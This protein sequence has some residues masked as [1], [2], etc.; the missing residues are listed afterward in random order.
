[1]ATVPV[2]RQ[3]SSTSKSGVWRMA[4]FPSDGLAAPESEIFTVEGEGRPELDEVIPTE[5]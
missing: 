1:M 2:S 4:Y 3:R 5:R